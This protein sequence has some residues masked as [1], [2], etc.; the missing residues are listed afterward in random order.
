MSASAPWY[1]RQAEF[2]RDGLWPRG[3]RKSSASYYIQI[4]TFSRADQAEEREGGIGFLMKT[5]QTE[6][7]GRN[8][9]RVEG[10]KGTEEPS[11]AE[12]PSRMLRSIRP[13]RAPLV[14]G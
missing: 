12:V 10:D 6:S 9:S 1:G 11:S 14:S 4:N 3:Q 5:G 13:T 2:R 8:R 7:L